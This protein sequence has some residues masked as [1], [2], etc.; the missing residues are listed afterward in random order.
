MSNNVYFYNYYS[1][2]EGGNVE[3]PN[4]S[5]NST[6]PADV[7]AP[8]PLPPNPPSLPPRTLAQQLP[9]LP[10]VP[11]RKPPP[12]LPPIPPRKR[13]KNLPSLPP[14]NPKN[15]SV[16]P[17]APSRLNTKPTKMRLVQERHNCCSNKCKMAVTAI[18]LVVMV[19]TVA[20]L[21]TSVFSL[22]TQV[23]NNGMDFFISLL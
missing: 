3:A 7:V 20:T 6:M 18:V 23:I 15:T 5:L 1:F 14:R 9:N 11:P 19:I 4:H 10:P 16:Y 21:Y 13:P 2:D 12:N 8:P 22:T 17:S